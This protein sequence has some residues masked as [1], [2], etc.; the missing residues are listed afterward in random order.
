VAIYFAGTPE[1][2]YQ[3]EMWL[4]PVE[5]LRRPAVV[6][7]RDPEVL[8]RL[9]PTS[10]PV[11][12]TPFNGTLAKL[13]LPPSVATLF[14]THSG[15]NVAMLRRREV[16]SV[17]V[18]HGDSDK[19]DSVNPFARVYEQIWVAGPLGRRR[20]AEAAVGVQPKALV[21]IGRPQ[22]DDTP[23]GPPV[24]TVLYAPTWEGWGD[25]PHHS[26]LPH[27]GPDLVRA[28]LARGDLRVLY[29]PHPLTGRRDPRLR[30]AD[31]EVRALLRAAGATERPFPRLGDRA[32]GDLLD[33]AVATG[34]WPFSRA[35]ELAERAVAEQAFWSA[36]GSSDHRILDASGPGLASC[37]A[38]TS[39]LVADVSS[40]VS[41]FLVLDRPYGVVDTRGL[42]AKAF[43][44]RF[45]SAAGGVVVTAD[46]SNLSDLCEGD[47]TA[48]ARR[49]LRRD[50]LGDPATSDER[51]RAAVDRLVGGS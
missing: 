29:R 27:V 49:R 21:A 14:V 23:A 22:I 28:L 5:R 24:P 32:T 48:T 35:D 38:Q 46:L 42:G 51:F 50:A 19:P 13:P 9:A 15:N 3:P 41:D 4:E 31:A 7:L 20:Y 16:R 43:V 34:R 37:L 12:C 39:R 30:R 18:G 10:L 45:P 26:S 44:E 33:A 25:D 36:A 1:E 11:V 8:A 6:V 17:F 40:V 47:R 2:V